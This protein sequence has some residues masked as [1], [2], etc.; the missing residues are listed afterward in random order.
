MSRSAA[1]TSPEPFFTLGSRYVEIYNNVF[2]NLLET[3]GDSGGS[4]SGAGRRSKSPRPDGTTT[5]PRSPPSKIEVREHPS[6]GVFLSGGRGLR[7]PVNSA[8]AV[9]ALVSHGTKARRTA[10]TG[11]NDRSSRSHAILILEIEATHSRTALAVR[12]TSPCRSATS[13]L[14]G[15]GGAA[16]RANGG[17]GGSPKGYRRG[18]RASIVECVSIGKMQVRDGANF[19]NCCRCC[20]L[21]LPLRAGRR[22]L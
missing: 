8:N 11:L 5:P 7:V 15:P 10:S 2:H 13:S 12:S 17:G 19:N 20:L 3:A 16:G 9:A 18:R 22:E 14:A 4:S 1:F 6:R 21:I